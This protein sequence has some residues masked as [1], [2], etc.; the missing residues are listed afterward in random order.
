MEQQLKR[1]ADFPGAM[2]ASMYHD[3]RANKPAELNGCPVRS[4]DSVNNAAFQRRRMTRLRHSQ[5]YRDGVKQITPFFLH[6]VQPL[7]TN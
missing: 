5:T 7:T 3:L 2:V 4:G 1:I 6:R